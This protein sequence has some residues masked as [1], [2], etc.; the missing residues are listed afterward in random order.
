MRSNYTP[1]VNIIR[2]TDRD[3]FYIPTPN[4]I[5]IV[6][7]LV[8][9]FKKG[10][11]SYNIVGSY[12]TG[13]SSFLL[14]LEQSLKTVKPYFNAN[15]ISNQSFDCIKIVGSYQSLIE[16]FAEEL[17]VKAKSN[18]VDHIF[19]EIFN[20]YH[21][22]G[23]KNPLL[24][25][26]V[27]EFGKFLEFASQNNP[28][29]ELYFIQQLAEFVNNPKYNIVLITTIHQSFES[30]A[31]SLSSFQRQEWAKVKGRFREIPF[32]E[33]VEQL[34]HLASEH[35]NESFPEKTTKKN[36]EKA[37]S[38]FTES[39][40]FNFVEQYSKEISQ[41][42]FPLDLIAANVLT[43]SLQRYG[44]NER[45]LFSF[46]ESTD[47][48][49]ISRY[50]K[51]ESQF[52]NL[53]NVYDYLNF[54]FYS[55]IS[56][57]YNPDFSA[58][59]SIKA[60]LEEVE[61]AFDSNLSQYSK[62]IK[63]IGLLNIFSAAGSVLNRDFLV[64]YAQTC[65]GIPSPEFLIDGLVTKKI[66]L[67]RNYSQRYIL[68]EGTDLDIQTALIEAANKVNEITDVKTILERYY[69]L[70]P[71]LAKRHSYKKG[72]PRYFKF[73]ISEYPIIDKPEGEV[74]GFINLIFN[75]KLTLKKVKEDSGA[76]KEAVL[77]GFYRNSKEIK[78]LLY[79]IE[80]SQK[81]LEENV[82]D[83]VAKKEL[84]NIIL[85]QQN[86]LN[87][88]ILNNLYGD[89]TE[90]TWF[91]DGEEQ[92]LNTKKE[93]NELLSDICDTVYNGTPVFK[94]E[95]VNKHKISSAIYTAK[96][97]L[98][99]ALVNNWDQEDLGFSKEKFP[100]EKTIFI[101]LLK[102]TGLATYS[103]E[104]T[105]EVSIANRSTFKK[106]WKSSI[107]FLNDAKSEKKNVAEFVKKL[108]SRPF[109]LKQGFIDLWVPVFLFLKRDD[110]ALFGENGFIPDINEDVLE[111]LSKEPHEFFIKTFDIEG[112]KLDIFNS[113]RKFL[114][115]ETK[116]K[117]SN[118]TFIET[119]KPF[120]VF[121]RQL[122]DYS[123]NTKRLSKEAIAIRFAIIASQDPEK[124][125]FEDFPA[126]L[127]TSLNQLKTDRNV[128]HGYTQTLQ[129][130]LKELRTSY[131]KLIDR[132]EEFILSEVIY[133]NCSFD[134]YK[135]KLQVRY[136]TLKKH[137]LLPNQK[138]FV[139]R[140]DSEIEDKKAWLSSICQAVVGKSLESIKDEE[141]LILYDKFKSLILELDSLT[142]LSK[143][144][145]DENKE[146]VLG[147]QFNS[148]VDGI[149][150]SLVRLPKGKIKEVDEIK[151]SVKSVLSK[152]K[153]LNIAALTKLLKELVQQ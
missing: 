75:E 126:A 146:E 153:S 88:Y 86:L 78:A 77:Y 149:K 150:Q 140:I 81:V 44:Q 19:S 38:S 31:F 47:H 80:K 54:N 99:K 40:A 92:K 24:F 125:F 138:T 85:H 3:F 48:T 108:Q 133:E 58:W 10:I 143:E 132:F 118:D 135:Q 103:V 27:D 128:L 72:T 120:L 42:I 62:L 41:K 112:V 142:V 107:D 43:L 151:K 101:T 116:D 76:Q 11:R 34:L 50:S 97:S 20:R 94:N 113:Y 152:D 60:S 90:V 79:E 63:T 147:L 49:S 16:A 114:T 93:F 15:F 9:D 57:K 37:Y 136:R 13:K 33:P 91:W 64:G 53:A 73:I 71:V 28:E 65:L 6:S 137:L 111:I 22:L 117:V 104:I 61:R 139:Q 39:K 68:F 8:D 67:F 66:I 98:F 26:E 45:S 29:K 18:L 12:G 110:F 127:G 121:Y 1:S 23:K 82:D 100:P 122:P 106:L 32:N 141:E 109:K 14:A 105:K 70:P 17:N 36:I 124:S 145:I 115:Q 51:A 55:F 96:K 87:H 30:Y 46:L 131:E 5:R 95:L 69:D 83:K 89:R 144:T 119:I 2:D 35:I 74:D 134:H 123:K 148:F 7:Q 56:S 21:E 59:S 130:V 84:Q 129:N 4:G 52:Y 102:E 25:I